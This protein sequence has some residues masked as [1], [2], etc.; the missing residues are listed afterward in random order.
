M[1]TFWRDRAA[2]RDKDPETFFPIGIGTKGDPQTAE[3]K[4]FCRAFCDVRTECLAWALGTGEQFGV[5]AGTTPAERR[6]MGMGPKQGIQ[7]DRRKPPRDGLCL[8]GHRMTASNVYVD[9][10]GHHHCQQCRAD[11]RAEWRARSR[12]AV[13]AS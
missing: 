6:A 8:H 13:T 10:R 9:G 12:E 5:W 7:L 11:R 2:C 1:D 4:A 3:A